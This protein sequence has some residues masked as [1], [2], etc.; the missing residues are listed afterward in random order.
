MVIEAIVATL[1]AAF[2]QIEAKPDSTESHRQRNS[3]MRWVA[4]V[5]TEGYRL[6][7]VTTLPASRLNAMFEG[8]LGSQML[9]QFSVVVTDAHQTAV[10]T[11]RHPF[12]AALDALGVPRE[13]AAAVVG[14]ERER[15]EAE[16]YGMPHCVRFGDEIPT[17]KVG[18]GPSLWSVLH[19][20]ARRAA[21]TPSGR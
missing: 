13:C 14:S 3:I 12:D 10:G 17:S 15:Q 9:D 7:L 5:S 21:P 6:G 4:K 20:D 19:G 16:Q 2:A 8:T 1:D 11:K 18:H